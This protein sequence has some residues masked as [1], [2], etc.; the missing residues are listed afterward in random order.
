MMNETIA[1]VATAAGEAGIGIIRISG[2]DACRILKKLFRYRSGKPLEEP[3]P[4][5]MLYGGIYNGRE[6]RKTV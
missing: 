4:R 6:Q 2:P 3:E 5:R 1:A